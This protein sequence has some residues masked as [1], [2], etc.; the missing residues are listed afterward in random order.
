M[1]ESSSDCTDSGEEKPEEV[2]E[3]LVRK[4]EDTP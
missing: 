4:P 3:P 1:V 2:N